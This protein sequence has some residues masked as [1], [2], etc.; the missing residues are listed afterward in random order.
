MAIKRSLGRRQPD[1]F[2]EALNP[3]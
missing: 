1:G 3:P 2:M